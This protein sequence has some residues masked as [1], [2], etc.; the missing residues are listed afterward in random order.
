MSDRPPRYV[1]FGSPRFAAIVLGE[2]IRAGLGPVA[3]VCNPD[4][5]VGRKQVVTPPLV[6]TL[7]E[8]HGIPVIQPEKLDAA[9]TDAIAGQQPEC[10]VVAAYAKILPKSILS[11]P[12][13]GSVGVHPSLLPKFRGASPI[14]SAILAG[15]TKTGAT[16][17]V[18]DEKTDHGPVLAQE[19]LSATETPAYLLPYPE[20]EER[21]AE[22]GARLLVAALPE[23][24]A[25]RA[26]A[27]E[28]NEA[29]A[30]YTK[31]FSTEDGFVP[32]NDLMAA[33][34]GDETRALAILRKINALNPDP[35]A[36]TVKSGVRTRLLAA[37]IE[38][39]RLR[40]TSIQKAGGKP[41]T[42]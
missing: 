1:F 6:K 9:A 39:G 5:P 33:L 19:P 20:L 27:E 29:L 7:A 28:Q 26:S 17:Y 24:A 18:M 10:F 3:V 11:L 40:L 13:R 22:L 36:W 8:R 14:Q 35:G 32:E 42:P 30:T 4:R 31:K 15:E 2:L 34:A 23:F 38:N 41:R 37:V 12:P 16:I 25:G 21:L